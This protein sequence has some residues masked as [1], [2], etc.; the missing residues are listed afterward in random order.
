MRNDLRSLIDALAPDLKTA[1]DER[2]ALRVPLLPVPPEIEQE[3]EGVF[4]SHPSC[5]DEKYPPLCDIA[6]AFLM[7]LDQSTK[8][9][10]PGSTVTEQTPPAGQYLNLMKCLFLVKKMEVAE[11]LV[12]ATPQSHWPSYFEELKEVGCPHCPPAF[13]ADES[14]RLSHECDRF[15]RGMVAPRHPLAEADEESLNFWIVETQGGLIDTVTTRATLEDL[16]EM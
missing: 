5:Q 2:D 11:E 3:L 4:R 16:M 12:N 10:Q 15:S 14:Q 1:L 13:D 6:D 8:Y 7:S 9:F